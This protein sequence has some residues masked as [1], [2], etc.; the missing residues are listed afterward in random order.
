MTGLYALSSFSFAEKV[1]RAAQD[2]SACRDP[3]QM[4]SSD[5]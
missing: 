3:L 4:L 1:N 5:F 2:S